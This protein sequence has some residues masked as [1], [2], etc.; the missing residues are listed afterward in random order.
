MNI[1]LSLSRDQAS[2]VVECVLEC[3]NGAQN[4]RNVYEKMAGKEKNSKYIS[5]G[6]VISKLTEL[7]RVLINQMSSD[8][9]MESIKRHAHEIISL[10][11][12]NASCDSGQGA[13]GKICTECGSGHRNTIALCDDCNSKLLIEQRGMW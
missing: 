3:I 1:T 9:D 8:G 7:H 11:L 10:A 2:E 6:R 12:N 13:I 4:E 5:L